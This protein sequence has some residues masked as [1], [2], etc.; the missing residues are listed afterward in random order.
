V[1]KSHVPI[2]LGQ[3]PLTDPRSLVSSALFHALLVLLA[4]L[5]ALNMALPI[6][7]SSRPKALYAELDP[8]DNRADIPASPGQGGGGLGD[9]GGMSSLPF[10]PPADG[11]KPQGATRDPVADTLLAEILPS[12]QPKPSE[13]LQRALPGP[14]TTGQGL[15]PGSGS[16]GGGGA[17]GGSG[18]GAGR[19]IGPG[20]QFF[21]ARDHAHSFAY[22]IDCSGSMA[23]RNSLDIAKRE[24]FSSINQLPPDAQFAV[25]FYNLQ[26]RMLSDPLG[27]RGLMAATVTNK[28]RVQTQLESISPLGGTD[29]MLALREALKLK[30]EVIFFLTDADLMTNG[31]VNE[32]LAE[33]GSTRIQ[34]VEFGRGTELG[35]RTP[36]GRL[37]TTTGG[38]YLYIDVSKFPRSS[39][40]F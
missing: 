3:T 40:G 14:Q 36:L 33:V 21:G 30:P 20:T 5:T 39:G 15:I 13:T 18:G 1:F 35:Q 31:D 27:Q 17:G 7:E 24:M 25:I 8:V 38:S 23:T 22:V 9:I 16:G 12:T 34:A 26:A 19:G 32:I 11:T 4:S 10:T 2:A 28:A 29:H 37:A 6:A